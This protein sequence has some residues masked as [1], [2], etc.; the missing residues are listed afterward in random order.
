M[1]KAPGQR[2]SSLENSLPNPDKYWN[3]K[4]NNSILVNKIEIVIILIQLNFDNS[5][6][7]L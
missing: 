1:G 2:S 7:E 4:L 3:A 6:K 5:N